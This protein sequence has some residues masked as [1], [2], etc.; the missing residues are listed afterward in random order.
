MRAKRLYES[1]NLKWDSEWEDSDDIDIATELLMRAYNLDQDPSELI[2][3]IETA[4][5][6]IDNL[7]EKEAK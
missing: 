2:D 3:F 6:V 4:L 7:Q 1:F 5:R